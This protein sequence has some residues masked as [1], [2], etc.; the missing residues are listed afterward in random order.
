V[1]EKTYTRTEIASEIRDLMALL[2][3][4]S[5]AQLAALLRSDGDS[6][7]SSGVVR[8]YLSETADA[9]AKFVKLLRARRLEVET[10]LVAGVP[11]L[12]LG[13]TLHAIYHV[14][15][16]AHIITILSQEDL[17]RADYRTATETDLTVT[18][19]ASLAVPAGWLHRCVVCGRPFVAR[20][21][22]SKACYRRDETGALVCRKEWKRRLRR[23]A[24]K[25]AEM[26]VSGRFEA[27]PCWDTS[28]G[29]RAILAGFSGPL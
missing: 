3:L 19:L 12:T 10:Q 28:F 14:R 29:K 17:D 22:T 23:M 20:S 2:Q 15:P 21:T 11:A 4:D 26:A 24:A 5:S 16:K 7:P 18:V 1:G 13:E 6:Y 25:R 9:G 27:L 8:T